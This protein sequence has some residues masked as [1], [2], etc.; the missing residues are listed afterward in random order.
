MYRV[1]SRVLSRG[2]SL[3]VRAVLFKTVYKRAARGRTCRNKRLCRTGIGQRVCRRCSNRRSRF[4]YRDIN[5]LFSGVIVFA[6]RDCYYRAIFACVDGSRRE[7]VCAFIIS[8][9]SRAFFIICGILYRDRAAVIRYAYVACGYG[10]IGLTA[11]I[12]AYAAATAIIVC[13]YAAGYGTIIDDAARG[14]VAA[15]GCSF[16]YSNLTV[17]CTAYRSY[18]TADRHVRFRFRRYV[19]GSAE[20][21]YVYFT[22]NGHIFGSNDINDCTVGSRRVFDSAFGNSFGDIH[23]ICYVLRSRRYRY[24]SA[25]KFY[26][27]LG[28]G[29]AVRAENFTAE[30]KSFLR[31]RNIETAFVKRHV[32]RPFHMRFRSIELNVFRRYLTAVRILVDF[33]DNIVS[34]CGSVFNRQIAIDRKRI[35]VKI[36]IVEYS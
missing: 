7:F 2:D 12:T 8:Y 20:R 1:A 3:A 5:R 32:R 13:V 25:G 33:S 35:S 11:Y 19:N 16:V 28:R 17:V 29:F 6:C 24:A 18:A 14:N 31:R 10:R 23:V 22:G 15:Y 30:Y 21:V 36:E 34:A 9:G 27:R 4:A 26:I